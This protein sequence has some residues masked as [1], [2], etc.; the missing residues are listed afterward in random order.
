MSYAQAILDSDLPPARAYLQILDAMN[1]RHFS[2][3]E[4]H[5]ASFDQGLAVLSRGERALILATNFRYQ[6]YGDGFHDYFGNTNGR[7]AHETARALDLLGLPKAAEF[8]RRA[9]STCQVPDPLP[10]G[11]EYDHTEIEPPALAELAR[12]Y[13]QAKPDADFEA[14]AVR[15]VRQHPEEFA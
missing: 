6:I 12:E 10:E 11:Y 14:V 3:T 2:P 5:P 9:L 8:L 15:Y 1:A 7:H 4:G 13:Y